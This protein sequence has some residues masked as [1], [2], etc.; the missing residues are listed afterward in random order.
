MDKAFSDFK[1]SHALTDDDITAK[2]TASGNELSASFQGQIDDLGETYAKKTDVKADI[3]GF[4][5][6]MSENYQSKTDAGTMQKD[7][8][9]ENTT[10]FRRHHHRS[11]EPHRGGF[12]GAQG[13]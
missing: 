7:P 4:R 13:R 12:R 10:D 8:R 1:E 2:I 6:E 3:D 5:T 11:V 9:V